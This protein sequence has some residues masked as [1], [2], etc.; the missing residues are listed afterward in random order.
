MVFMRCVPFC[1]I[2]RLVVMTESLGARSRPPARIIFL[3]Y[4]CSFIGC[5]HHGC[6][7]V[8]KAS[9]TMPKVF[10]ESLT[11]TPGEFL[12]WF[13]TSIPKIINS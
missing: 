11:H 1:D 8:Y 12:R 13:F 2:S 3:L 6:L 4:Y 10:G 5:S 7:C 9:S